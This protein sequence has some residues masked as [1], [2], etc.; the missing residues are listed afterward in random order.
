MSGNAHIIGMG[1]FS[2]GIL[3]ELPFPSNT[4]DNVPNNYPVIVKLFWCNSLN[5]SIELAN[6]FQFDMY[7]AATWYM[8]VGDRRDIDEGK[9]LQLVNKSIGMEGHIDI[10]RMLR[11]NGFQ[12]FFF[13][14]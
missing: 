4:Y 2:L 3:D 8:P 14:D 11:N 7:D 1:P 12:F 9:L 5:F 13:M 6:I 10:F